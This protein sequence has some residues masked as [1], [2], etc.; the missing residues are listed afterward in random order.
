LATVGAFS[1]YLENAIAKAIFHNTDFP[2]PTANVY[3]ALFIAAPDDTG[4]GTEVSTSGT[5]Y[6][7]VAVSTG[8]SG[9][10]AG[11]GWDITDGVVTNA[12]VLTWNTATASWGAITSIGIFDAASGGNLLIRGNLDGGG[13][14]IGINHR[15]ELGAGQLQLTVD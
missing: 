8:T 13:E 9:T 6:A 11:S 7:R 12:G 4:G 2:A 3:V 15:F 14:T 1:D 5:A 10:G